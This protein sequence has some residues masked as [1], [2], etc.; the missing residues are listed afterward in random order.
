[1]IKTTFVALLLLSSHCFADNLQAC[2]NNIEN[3]WTSVYYK[4]PKQQQIRSYQNLLE[5][6]SKLS[7][8]YPNHS[9]PLFWQA[10]VKATYADHQDAISALKSIHEAR[11]L[12]IK[13]LQIDPKTMNGSAY[14]TLGTLYYMVP[15]WP[16]AYGDDSKA[17][18]M[19]Q[20]ALKINPNGIDA[21]Y[22]YGDFLLSNNKLT[23]AGDYFEK[24]ANTPISPDQSYANLR[25]KQEANIALM[26]TKKR[27]LINSTASLSLSDIKDILI[28]P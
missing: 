17:Q 12:L 18:E 11:D 9:E 26:K 3:E 15:K 22:Y 7:I 20:A 2:L 25:L 8:Q 5:K 6:T 24:A 1:M 16:I 21:N 10:V 19:L 4:L 14:V 28:V 23:E 13:A 27:K